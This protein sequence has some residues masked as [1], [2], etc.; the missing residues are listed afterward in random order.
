MGKTKNFLALDFGASNG[1]AIVGEYNGKKINLVEVH[2][3]ENRPVF[4]GG[5]YYWDFLSLFY[6]LKTGI[7]NAVKKYDRIDS[8]GVDTWG[9]DFGLLDKNK[10]LL[11][12]PVHYRDKRTSGLL[13]SVR[14]VISDWELYEL[15]QA[16]ILE[17]NTLYQ[18][19]SIKKINPTFLKMSGTFYCWG[20][21][22]ISCPDW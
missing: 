6:E 19:F 1:R 22:L 5:T 7:S 11:S 8:I 15:T 14:K 4:A 17:I 20:I 10:N 2:R 21:F 16:Q 18:L 13:K 12:N 9:C 3:F